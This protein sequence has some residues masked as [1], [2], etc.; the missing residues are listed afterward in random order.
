D[1]YPAGSP[2]P[3]ENYLCELYGVSRTVIRES[4]KVL[5][6]KGLFR[7]KPRIG[8]TVCDKDD[9]NI[10]AADVLEWMGPYLQEFYLLGCI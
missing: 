4:L 8:T 10:L 7:G 3:R 2:L 6:S 5:E 9:W 1:R